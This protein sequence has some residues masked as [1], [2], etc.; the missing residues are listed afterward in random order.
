MNGVLSPVRQQ[1]A[2]T[3]KVAEAV[4]FVRAKPRQELYEE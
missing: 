3:N 1:G 4:Y 2:T